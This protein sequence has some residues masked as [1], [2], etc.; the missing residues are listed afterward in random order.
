MNIDCHLLTLPSSKP[1]WIKAAVDSVADSAHLHIVAGIQDALGVSRVK[2][3][4]LGTSEYVTTL[5]PDDILIDAYYDAAIKMLVKYP[6]S[7]CA[8]PITV[9]VIDDEFL[10]PNRSGYPC[11]GTVWR[12][13]DI[14]RLLPFMCDEPYSDFI[15]HYAVAPY[16]HRINRPCYAMRHHCEQMHR[17]RGAD[18]FAVTYNKARDLRMH[19][20]TLFGDRVAP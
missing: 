11:S 19:I 15:L 9:P 7:L 5:D 12:R 20:P 16:S 2:G 1:E 6:D 8:Y 18:F 3:Y 13:C 14:D 17:N 4:S 10:P